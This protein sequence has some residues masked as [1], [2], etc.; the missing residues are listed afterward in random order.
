MPLNEA[1]TRAK[2]I[3][4]ALHARGWSEDLIHRE[5]TAGEVEIVA[6]RPPERSGRHRVSRAPPGLGR[7]R[8]GDRD[9]ARVQSALSLRPAFQARYAHAGG[10]VG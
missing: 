7:P 1:D 3:D 6:G 8:S 4:P 5:T 10:G 9:K 2:L